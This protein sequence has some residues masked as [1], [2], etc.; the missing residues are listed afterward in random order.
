MLSFAWIC[1]QTTKLLNHIL[2]VNDVS[3][4]VSLDKIL[5]LI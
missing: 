5:N 4:N 3:N 2:K 1:V